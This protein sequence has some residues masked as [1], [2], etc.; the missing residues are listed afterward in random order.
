MGIWLIF[1]TKRIVRVVAKVRNIGL[2]NGSEEPTELH[3]NMKED[4]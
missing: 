2:D 4:D 1:G 3:E